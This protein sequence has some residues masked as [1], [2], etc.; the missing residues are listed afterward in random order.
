MSEFELSERKREL[1]K[2]AVEQYIESASPITSGGITST[3]L[4]NLSSATIRNEL[5]ALEAMGYLKQLHTSSG[6]VPTTKGYRFF[7]NELTKE[8]PASESELEFIKEQ[9]NK[10]TANLKDMVSRLAKLVSDA[11]NY[12][13]VVCLNGFEKLRIKEIKIIP[14][15]TMQA[16]MLIQ[17]TSGILNNTIDLTQ[18]ISEESC[19]DVSRYL[20]MKLQGLAISEM[21]DNIQTIHNDMANEIQEYNEF[22]DYVLGTLV[23]ITKE[24]NLQQS[25]QASGSTKLLN[26]PEYA[27]IEK[28]KEVLEALHDKEQLK[29]LL[30]DVES[31]DDEISFKIGE[32]NANDTFKDCAIAKADYKVNGES[33]ASI[34]IIGPKRMD[35]AKIS[36]ALKFIVDETKKLNLLGKNDQELQD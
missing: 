11:T 19:D 15:M 12:P 9:F 3:I 35:Y 29:D 26:N 8:C 24:F 23:E 22:F 5:N 33:I 34:G 4:D 32:E 18:N 36:S 20:T 21:V 27:N 1:L 30:I 31:E 13:T 16:L 14:L 17:T 25:V 28:A 2:C 10:R 6:R 7:V